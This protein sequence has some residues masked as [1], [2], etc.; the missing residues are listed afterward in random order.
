MILASASPRRKELLV[1]AGFA[2]T[3][4]PADIDETPLPGER[5]TDLVLRL[6]INKA[7]ACMDSCAS[8]ANNEVILAADTI[9]WHDDE[10]LGKPKD[11]ED[12]RR[13]LHILSG[14]TH[15]VSTGV[16]LIRFDIQTPHESA[17]VD[18][19]K[20]R[21]RSLTDREIDQYVATGE[22]LDKAGAYGIQGGAGAFVQSIEGDYSNVV[23]LPIARVLKVLR[24]RI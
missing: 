1:L 6:A 11:A 21:F 4:M 22:P 9:V 20:V 19:T 10:V 12:A 15:H 13:M 17:F 16:C 3:I 18:T 8:H 7:H 14:R 2:P 5:P 24:D 23:G